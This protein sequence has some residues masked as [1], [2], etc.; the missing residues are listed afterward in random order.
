[1]G[2]RDLSINH[3]SFLFIFH[4]VCPESRDYLSMLSQLITPADQNNGAM[5]AVSALSVGRR[6]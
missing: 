3:P 2:R 5:S 6:S 4:L 1:M